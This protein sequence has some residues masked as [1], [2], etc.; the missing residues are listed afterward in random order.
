MIR[1]WLKEEKLTLADLKIM[2]KRANQIQVP[3][4]IGRLPS[5]IDTKE[6]FSRFFADQWKIFILIYATSITWDLLK[7]PD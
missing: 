6:G 2:Q 5:K 3:M 4:D 1:L 7:G